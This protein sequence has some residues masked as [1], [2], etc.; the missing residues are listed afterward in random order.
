MDGSHIFNISTDGNKISKAAGCFYQ[1][2]TVAGGGIVQKRQQ[3]TNL[4][5]KTQHLRIKQH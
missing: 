1:T 3:I 2:K 5:P 4:F